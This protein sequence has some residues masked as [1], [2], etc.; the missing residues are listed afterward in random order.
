MLPLDGGLFDPTASQ[1]AR[2][3]SEFKRDH[4]RPETFS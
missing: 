2:N 4:Y 1:Y 3:V